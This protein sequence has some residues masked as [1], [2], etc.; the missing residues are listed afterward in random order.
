MQDLI[1]KKLVFMREKG[2][3]EGIFISYD[4]DTGKILI[5]DPFNDSKITEIE[6]SDVT[7]VK[8]SETDPPADI[9]PKIALSQ[10]LSESRMYALFNDAFNIYGPFEDSF[11]Y[12]VAISMKKFIKDQATSKIKIVVGSD[13]VFGRIGLS[14]ARLM[15]DRVEKLDLVLD[16][17]L[18]DI[19]S[20]GYLSAF[21]N[22]KGELS[23]STENTHYTLVL[24]ACNRHYSFSMGNNT[25]DQTIIMDLPNQI[26]IPNFTHVSLGFTPE[27]FKKAWKYY[28][29]IDVGFGA[30]LAE[31]YGI[32][33]K[34]KNSLTKE[35]I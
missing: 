5:K 12:S 9:S 19:K 2:N 10:G 34:Y 1:G 7:E 20:L 30:A 26:S 29:I 31:K 33:I 3:I 21:Y 4:E 32:F 22:S 27:Y 35:L 18:A 8:I 14:F 6:I 17:G 15:M 23:Q 28:Y 11:I 13:D 24:F 25:A 16:C